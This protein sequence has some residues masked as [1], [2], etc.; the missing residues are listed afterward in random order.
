MAV[1]NVIKVNYQLT[2][3]K[4]TGF[5]GFDIPATPAVLEEADK[6]VY[7]DT[8]YLRE[9]FDKP[10]INV[11]DNYHNLSDVDYVKLKA[12]KATN[13]QP[14]ELYY[15]CSPYPLAGGT[16][17]LSLELDALMTLGGA[18][19]IEYTSGWQSR[20][21][22]SKEEDVLFGNVASEDWLPRKTL[23]ISN[24]YKIDLPEVSGDV[25]PD[26]DLNMILTNVDLKRSSET[27]DAIETYKGVVDAGGTYTPVMYIPKIPI[28]RVATRFSCHPTYD[29]HDY[30]DAEI[31]N[32]KAYDGDDST[33]R[34]NI[35]KLYSCGQLQLINSYVIPKEYVGHYAIHEMGDNA[36]HS[37]ARIQGYSNQF[38]IDDIPFI[39]SLHDYTVKNK[40]CFITYRTVS[41]MNPSSGAVLTKPIYELKRGN[42][43]SPTVR[44]WADPLPTGRPYARFIDDLAPDI[45]YFDTIEGT[46]WYNS[47]ISLEGGSGS[48]LNS[49]N[50]SFSEQTLNRQ[51]SMNYINS[52]ASYQREG[53]AEL[54]NW[55]GYELG[56][57]QADRNIAMGI[58]QAGYSAAKLPI[59]ELGSDGKNHYSKMDVLG[60]VITGTKAVTDNMLLS[61]QLH[62][63][64]MLQM[65]NTDINKGQI[66]AG[67]ISNDSQIQQQINENKI[68]ELV[69]NNVVAPSTLFTPNIDGGLYG[70]NRFY[71]YEIRKSEEDL[72]SEDLYYQM[73]G[74]NGLNKKL[75]KDC[76]KVRQY[77]N[78]VQAY[79]INI[80]SNK[81]TSMRLKQKA[82]SQL[83]GGVRVW[84]VLPDSSYYEIN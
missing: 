11:N 66:L 26:H 21:H 28:N 82:I 55:F 44:I 41:I 15:F 20:G 22:I 62:E 14:T 76:F 81:S 75:T 78:F 57:R 58:V 84:N 48:L 51:Q 3:Y 46:Q 30:E 59:P 49:L 5:N 77:Y 17:A 32:V 83:N 13:N 52:L 72:K 47:Q 40:K 6:V 42:Y 4:N 69:N 9:D 7:N 45:A 10:V 31:P 23:E 37:F 79:N 56:S 67:G 53:L 36:D 68:G 34:D 60:G 19:N 61:A 39:Y 29:L 73:F 25:R 1:P 54:G 71:V 18:P 80:K 27:A 65:A 33:V 74:Y 24:Y 35:E 8:Y 70:L 64:V 50:A 38:T 2:V 12:N 16:T 63:N 43:T